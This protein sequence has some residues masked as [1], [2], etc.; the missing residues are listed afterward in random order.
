[1]EEDDPLAADEDRL[2]MGTA[3][4]DRD[5]PDDLVS[6]VDGEAAGLA[7]AHPASLV[8]ETAKLTA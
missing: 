4:A 3:L 5:G 2:G 6:R 7:R 1:M 8:A